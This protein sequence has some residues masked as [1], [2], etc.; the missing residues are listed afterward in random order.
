[1]DTTGASVDTWDLGTS[2]WLS[3]HIFLWARRAEYVDTLVCGHIR[4]ADYE[5]TSV[6][7]YIGLSMWT[8]QSVGTSGWVRGQMGLWAHQADYMDTLV[9][10]HIRLPE[11]VDTLVCGHIR[12]IMWTHW[13]VGTL[14]WL[15]EHIGPWVHQ[16]EYVDKSVC[17]HIRLITWTHG[18]VGTSG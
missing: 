13:S 5:G 3:G 6:R 16:A 15:C 17:G 18:S 10:G 7:G 4:P 1:M 11:Y 2:S 8:N 9:C 12:L 14:G